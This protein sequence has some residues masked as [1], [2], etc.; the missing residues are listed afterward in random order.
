MEEALAA[1][2]RLLV[3]A[4]FGSWGLMLMT[5]PPS[6][7]SKG[8]SMPFARKTLLYLGSMLRMNLSYTKVGEMAV[9]SEKLS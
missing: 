5:E 1:A 9:G 8:V 7:R 6:G 3:R 2:P 4:V